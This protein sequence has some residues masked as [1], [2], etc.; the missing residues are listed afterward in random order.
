MTERVDTLEITIQRKRGDAW[1][2][3][4]E[5]RRTGH[6]GAVRSKDVLR[7]SEEQRTKLLELLFDP[8]PYGT[9][10]GKAL[11]S[12]DEGNVRDAFKEA[13]GASPDRLRVLLHVEDEELKCLHWERLCYRVHGKKWKLLALDQRLPF[14]LYL[15]A[16]SSRPFPAIGQHDLKALLLVAS[17]QGPDEYELDE[18]EVAPTVASIRRALGGID[19]D[20]LALVEGAVGPPSLD[21]LCEHLTVGDYTLLHIVAHG[22][23]M[24]E[25]TTLYLAHENNQVQY[26]SG[27]ELITRLDN[28]QGAKGLPHFVFLATCESAK[29]KT[30]A[31]L[32]GLAQRM[33]E[34]LGLPTV[35][36]MTEKVSLVTAEDLAAAFYGRLRQHGEPD[37]ALVEACAGLQGR[38]DV[39]VPVLYSRLE[40]RPLFSDTLDRELADKEVAF[41]LDKLERLLPERAPVRIDGFAVQAKSLRGMLGAK[42]DD[43][44][45]AA[46]SEWDRALADINTI[47]EDVLDLNFRGLALRQEPPDYDSRCPFPGLLAFQADY[48]EFFF[49]REKLVEQL[50]EKLAEHSF[51]PILGPSG[52]GKSSLVLAGLI[53]KLQKK[54][55]GLQMAYVTPGSDPLAQLEA[56]LAKMHDQSAVLVVDQFEELFTL[57][58]DEDKRR[59]FLDRLLS[60]AKSL[61]VVI[62]MRADFWGECAPYATL[63]EV[64]QARQELIAP[65]DAAEL[66]SA[67]EQQAGAVGL[68]FEATLANTILDD[69]KDEPGAM[70]LLQHALLELWKRRHGRGLVAKEYR[71]G[72]GGVQKAIARTADAVYEELSPAEQERVQDI[73]IRL[74]RL[75]E[76]AIR[77]EERRDTRRRVGLE[78]LVPA[79][80]DPA[81]TK[82]LMKRLADARL[83][84]TSVND[85]TQQ[86]EVEVAHEALIRHWPR[87]GD[88]LDEDRNSIRLRE[89]IGQAAQEWKESAENEKEREES[90]LVHRGG[91]LEDA[92]ELVRR[93]EFLNALEKAYV[94]ACVDLRDKE[95]AEKEERAQELAALL[96]RAERQTRLARSRELVVHAQTLLESEEDQSGSLALLLAR[97][98]ALTTYTAD[99]FVTAETD[100]V[101]RRAVEAAPPWRMTLPPQR[102]TASIRA[103]AWSP[104]GR[105]IVS[106]GDDRIARIWDAETGEQIHLLEGHRRSILSAAWSPDGR[107]IVTASSDNTA[108][109]WHAEKGEQ[110]RCLEGHK[111]T[112]RSAAWSPDGKWIVTAGA[113]R[114][115]RIWNAGTGTQSR[116]LLGHARGISSVAW[117]TDGK[118]ILTASADNTARIWHAETGESVHLLRGHSHPLRSA[119][120]SPDSRRVATTSMDGTARVWNVE[121]GEQIGTF[122]CHHGQVWS[123]AWSPDGRQLATAGTD[124]TVRLWNVR[125][126]EQI[127]LLAGH[128]SRVRSVAWNPNGEAILSAGDDQTARIWDA[129]TGKLRFVF[130]G[131]TDWLFSADFSP[132]G[133]WIVTASQDETACVW[134]AVTGKPARWLQGHTDKVFSATWSP[135]G[136][137]I[138]TA[139]QDRTARLW[140]PATGMEIHRLG[141]EHRVNSATWSRDGKSVVTASSDR[142]VAIWN[143]ST[144]KKIHSFEEHTDRVFDAAFSPDGRAVASAGDD[145]TVRVWNRET[146]KQMRHFGGH[147][148]RIWSVHWS[149]DG[150][151]IATASQDGTVRIWH[152]RTGQRVLLFERHGDVIRSVAWSPSGRMLVTAHGDGTARVWDTETLREVLALEGHETAIC[153]AAWS[154]DGKSIVTSS[155]DQTARIWD[156]RRGAQRRLLEGH[157]QAV[158]SAAWEPDQKRIVTGSDDQSAR[159]W[160]VKSGEQL[161]LLKGESARIF[162]VDWHPDGT[163]IVTAGAAPVARIWNSETGE[164]VRL[165]KGHKYYVLSARFSPDGRFVATSGDDDTVRIWDLEAGKQL[166]VLRGHT[167]KV[168]AVVWSPDGTFVASC[169]DDRTIRIWRAQS[170]EQIRLLKGHNDGVNAVA[171]SRDGAWIASGSGSLFERKDMT[172]RLWNAE[173]GEEVHRLEGHTGR[174]LSVAFSPDGQWVLTCGDDKVHCIWNTRTGERVR[175]LDDHSAEV[176]SG[177]WSPDGR[178][179]VTTSANRTVRIWPAWIEDLLKLAAGLIQRDPPIF[180]LAERRRFLHEEE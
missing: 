111:S 73:F 57:C 15:P 155:Y 124:Q 18:F 2:V 133:K 135:D 119:S 116:C 169:S 55:S 76:E 43:L 85:V 158:N 45:K 74:T 67:M 11:F 172:A 123:A 44:S 139:S 9:I 95:G 113:D 101:L 162:S 140:D 131:H 157:S 127:G 78:E 100:A 82:A 28:L 34:E 137:W 161:H 49:G 41:G 105:S 36:A 156:V 125:T 144:G 33:V 160:D 163:S 141:H 19:S 142:T 48:R 38:S 70:P 143:A 180:T 145:K 8:L 62:T 52:C 77:G 98:A 92:E 58:T 150:E 177:A 91:R 30:E 84:V 103:V 1:P 7:L 83:V 151:R 4:A 6:V 164:T 64:M 106:G 72:I 128:T 110:L 108:R 42:R 159:I 117:S 47:C 109:I 121:D 39:T 102:H 132:D 25:D 26:V 50:E 32:G 10:L 40:R 27:E 149:P 97:E 120:W 60:L 134:N 31:G 46:R 65:M 152:S 12:G 37:R 3:V 170:E 88:W 179:I 130:G 107:G 154:R 69:V 17:P 20:V 178:W 81:A 22:K 153:S 54:E 122:A 56:S 104:D 174:V 53:P 136:K 51:L 138:A 61:R 166:H 71:E 175:R 173:T 63:K 168:N 86:E 23:A 99:R 5:W 16:W 75:D 148:E 96:A 29:P 171:W 21:A 112:V 13:Q 79:G 14:S 115:M 94:E 93:P 118:W 80:S 87:L 68:R 165:L 35:L 89:S 129:K 114:T 66:R 146:G 90:L 59:A 126:E 167:E 147:N 176:R 24:K